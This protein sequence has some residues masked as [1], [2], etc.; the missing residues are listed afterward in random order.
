VEQIET[1]QSDSRRVRQMIL[2]LISNA[3]KFT[4]TGG[5]VRVTIDTVDETLL[6]AIR[7]N[8]IGI[9]PEEISRMFEPFAQ[10]DSSLG[11]VHTGTGLG[12]SLSAKLA[13]E[14]GGR[15]EAQSEVGSGSCFTIYLPL[16]G[17]IDREG[18]GPESD[19]VPEVQT[20][21]SDGPIV[22]H[23]DVDEGAFAGDSDKAG[24]GG[25]HVLLVDDIPANTNH[26]LDF[27]TAKGH[28]VAIARNGFEAVEKARNHPDIIFMDIQM[29]EMDGIDAIKAIRADKTIAHLYI[30]ALTSFAME[31]DEE[32]CLAAGA[33][34]YRSKP[35]GLQAV[36]DIVEGRLP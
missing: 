36:L 11:Q 9:P 2:N 15:I 18:E 30:V 22:T 26:L 33:N 13:T 20:L 28:D 29:P 31:E 32:R 4:N 19:M 10:L 7:D 35:I 17:E 16:L 1:I 21:V 3:I 23:N 27:L 14:L 6:I 34:E 12:L 25:L 5:R 24:A 8:G